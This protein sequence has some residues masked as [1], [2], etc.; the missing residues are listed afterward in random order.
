[1]KACVHDVR[2]LIQQYNCNP[3]LVRLAWHDAGTFDQAIPA[4][5]WPAC[6]GANGSIIYEEE[7]SHGAN[8]G[9]SKALNYLKPLKKKYPILSFADI[10]QM[11]SAEAIQLA[12]GPRI[13]MR[14]GRLDATQ[15]PKE[16][17]LPGAQKPFGDGAK[18][19]AEHLRNVFHRMGFSDQEIVC[20]SGAHTLGRAFKE[21]SGLVEEGY[22]SK[23]GTKY[24]GGTHRARRDGVEGVGMSGGKSWTKRWLSFDNGYFSEKLVASRLG[25][26][27]DDQL[28]S[29]ETDEAVEKAAGF[30]E[31]FQLYAVDEGKFFEDYAKAH[32]KLSEVGS[33]FFVAGGIRLEDIARL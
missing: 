4:S 5:N 1:M 23:R 30:K 3:I 8:A 29:F 7:L 19:A 11:A 20:L 33:K 21:R 27:A 32:K 24:T 28:I 6:G 2:Q 18:S 16:G 9:L 12:G 14:Y 13:D 31:W 26:K 15:C 22:G 10:I 25:G 17:N